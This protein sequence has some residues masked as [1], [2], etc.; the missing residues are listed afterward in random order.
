[1][2]TI[3][4]FMMLGGLYI[5]S[6]RRG[7]SSR[8]GFVSIEESHTPSIY[9][10]ENTQDVG[11][12]TQ[13]TDKYFNGTVNNEQRDSNDN[14]EFIGLSGDK[15]D[16]NNFQH[17][18]MKPFFGGKL[19]GGSYSNTTEA[20]LDHTQGSGSHIINKTEQAP[21]FKPQQDMGYAFGAPNQSEFIRSRMNPSLR[22]ANTKPWEEQRVAPGLSQGFN[23]THSN[24]GY[25]NGMEHR[26]MWMPR[27]VDDLRVET[28]PKESFSLQGREGPANSAIKDNINVCN[29]G[30][31]EKRGPDTDYELGPSRWFTTTGAQKAQPARGTE[32]MYDQNRS[33]TS[34]EY[35]GNGTQEGAT[36][37]VG[38]TSP[39][40]RNELGPTDISTPSAM[41]HG[42]SLGTDYGKRSYT[43]LPN[44][45]TTT[46][47]DDNI[48]G[49]YGS[50][51]AIVAPI[52]DIVRQTKKEDIV[53]N[54]RP[55]GNVQA[56]GTS[57]RVYDPSDRTKVTIKEQTGHLIGGNYLNLQN[58]GADAYTIQTIQPSFGLKSE[59]NVEYIGNAGN[60][61][62][63]E[64]MNY[65]AAYRQ[66]NNDKK[67]HRNRPH[68]G[69]MSI[70]NSDYNVSLSKNDI[71]EYREPAP[72][73]NITTIPS[74][75]NIGAVYTPD[76]V[77]T[78]ENVRNDPDLLKAFKENPYTQSLNS[79]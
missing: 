19:K 62:V 13:H 39:I 46:R 72:R 28:N 60:G 70:L 52:M 34:R 68:Q 49:V 78:T 4:S 26:E 77:D 2:E 55:S 75:D 71:N 40:Q 63:S 6:N 69:G 33:E 65:D 31:I 24:T 50:M 5:I 35:Y 29:Q 41:G 57:S 27:T 38:E 7:E 43:A 1:M 32:V 67:T 61:L 45:R 21:L 53:S 59:L 15:L 14:N 79:Y 9:P 42:P 66:H 36:Y 11:I 74:K 23:N 16:P 44:N 47:N 12:H 51:R 10:I 18:N 3:L 64:H 73:A 30:I 20:I 54:I 48:G 76:F 22:N 37:V 25:N 56:H 8:E 17:S 58:Q